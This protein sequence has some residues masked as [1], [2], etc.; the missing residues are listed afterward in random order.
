MKKTEFQKAVEGTP[1]ISNA[2]HPGIQALEHDDRKR[3]DCKN[4]A[5]GSLFLDETLK[6]ALPN[7]NRWDYA[8]GLKKNHHCEKVL[9]L[10]VHSMSSGQ[11]QLVV[12]KL[13][14]LKTWLR[15]E[16]PLLNAIER[17]FIWQLSG[18]DSGNPNDR[19]RSMQLAQ[20]HGLRR[21]VG[22]LDLSKLR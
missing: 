1:T 2:F 8:I 7:A 9:W 6:R 16:A 20:K 3:L 21:I 14:W 12:A 22:R 11:S 10:E 19:R 15:D 13:N 17:V 18:K 4:E 5:T